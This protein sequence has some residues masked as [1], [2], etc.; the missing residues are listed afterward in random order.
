M[1]AGTR[2]WGGA[3]PAAPARPQVWVTHMRPPIQTRG[4]YS[5]RQHNGR[6]GFSGSPAGSGTHPGCLQD[7]PCALQH[8]PEMTPYWA[9]RPSPMGPMQNCCR[10]LRARTETSTY[11]GRCACAPTPAPILGP[12]DHC[13]SAQVWPTQLTGRRPPPHGETTQQQSTQYLGSS[14]AQGGATSAVC[15]GEDG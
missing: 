15:D 5:G 13:K 11:P 8:S 1:P 4:L 3:T 10:G 2:F 6:P 12:Q 14:K 9:F 7:K